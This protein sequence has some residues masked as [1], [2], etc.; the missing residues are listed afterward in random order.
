MLSSLGHH[1]LIYKCRSLS[2]IIVSLKEYSCFAKMVCQFLKNVNKELQYDPKIPLLDIHWRVVV[3]VVESLSCVQLLQPHGLVA[4]QA[5]LSMD[6]LG[7][8]TWVG[9]HSL[10]QGIFLTQELNPR[11]LHWG[12]LFTNWATRESHIP[13]RMFIEALFLMAKKKWKQP[14]CLSNESINKIWYIHTIEEYSTWK[15]NEVL[16]CA[17][18]QM[19][20]ANI[21]L[22]ERSQPQK[23]TYCMIPCI[24]NVHKRQIH[25]DRK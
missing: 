24:C 5:P 8:N 18:T 14:N 3:V 22:N 1:F 25:T 2:M 11:L 12:R 7:K 23:T 4:C 20:L 21:R 17:T 16:A 10:L 13:K 6:S 19:N 9:C 15:G